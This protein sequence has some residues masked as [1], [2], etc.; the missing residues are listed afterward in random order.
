MKKLKV[1]SCLWLQALL[2]ALLPVFYFCSFS[3]SRQGD[4]VAA[5]VS[6]NLF[7]FLGLVL[8]A[9]LA[10]AALRRRQEKCDEYARRALQTADSLCFRA[11]L[12]FLSVILLPALLLSTLFAPAP[13]TTYA[14]IGFGKLMVSGIFALFLLRAALFSWIDRKGLVR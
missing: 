3:V 6:F 12:V 9:M 8:L 1:G 11:A 5:K 7:L 10:A 4:A 2:S 14:V 13:V